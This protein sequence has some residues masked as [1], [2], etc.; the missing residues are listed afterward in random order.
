MR[1]KLYSAFILATY[2]IFGQ[3]ASSCP[4][5]WLFP[6][7][8]LPVCLPVCLWS[9]AY[10][11]VWRVVSGSLE[12]VSRLRSVIPPWG[13]FFGGRWSDNKQPSNLI[14]IHITVR[15]FWCGA[16]FQSLDSFWINSIKLRFFHPL[17]VSM[18]CQ[19]IPFPQ[20]FWELLFPQRLWECWWY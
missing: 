20:A 19:S 11:E 7:V 1:I 3:S 4:Y 16:V 12:D 14:H 9:L 18:I 13:H 5:K 8:R 6:P 15:N 10:R 17:S 2:H